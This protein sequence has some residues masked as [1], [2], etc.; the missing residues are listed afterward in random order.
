MRNLR[1][2]PFVQVRLVDWSTNHE[3]A[4]PGGKLR[5]KSAFLYLPGRPIIGSARG[6][7]GTRDMH[8]L[9]NSAPPRL[10]DLHGIERINALRARAASQRAIV[11][12]PRLATL[13]SRLMSRFAG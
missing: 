12:Q 1:P 7:K 2:R 13:F 8:H 3:R 9:Q 6:T 5:I 11:P 10:S 4:D